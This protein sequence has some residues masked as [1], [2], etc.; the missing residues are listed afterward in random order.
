VELDPVELSAGPSDAVEN[1]FCAM[2]ESSM[3]NYEK[4]GFADLMLR[5]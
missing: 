3:S 5:A 2:V 4:A 1:R